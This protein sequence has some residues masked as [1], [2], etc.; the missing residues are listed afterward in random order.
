MSRTITV[1]RPYFLGYAAR[2]I[3]IYVDGRPVGVVKTNGTFT[4]E[5]D[6]GPHKIYARCVKE[7]TEEVAISAGGESYT[8]EVKFKIGLVLKLYL[9]Q[10]G[11]AAPAGGDAPAAQINAAMRNAASGG[12]L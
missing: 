3:D 6:E 12:D 5:L 1:S 4:C 9:E 11:V 2:A 8:Y 7:T 10:T